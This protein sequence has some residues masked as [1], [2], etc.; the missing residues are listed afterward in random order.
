MKVTNLKKRILLVDSLLVSLLW[1]FP[2]IL[3]HGTYQINNF[4]IYQ[5]LLALL[6]QLLLHAVLGHYDDH[7][8]DRL[9]SRRRILINA[10][11]S[12]FL[13]YF[14]LKFFSLFF[15]HS[16]SIR[17]RYFFLII[18]PL[19]VL[20]YWFCTI[21]NLKN[22][23]I[24]MTQKICVL[25]DKED[26]GR[27]QKWLRDN[28]IPESEFKI[29]SIIDVN[30]SKWINLHGVENQSFHKNSNLFDVLKEH[31]VVIYFPS[32]TLDTREA[33]NLLRFGTESGS[34]FDFGTFCGLLREMYPIDDID[35]DWYVRQS[36][37]LWLKIS[38]YL[39]FRRYFDFFISVILFICSFP[40]WIIA[41]LGI[42]LTSKGPIF[43]TQERI[44]RFGEKFQ[45]IKFRTMTID[46]EKSG[47]QMASSQDKRVTLFG[48]F[49]RRTRI[50]EL[51]QVLNVLKG[52]MSFIGP[53]PEREHFELILNKDL[54]LLQLRNFIAPGIT[55]L[56]QVNGD[57]AN[58]LD[59]Y[60][61]K[62]GYDL[63]YIL[64]LSPVLDLSILLRTVR[65]VLF[66]KGS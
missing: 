26:V 35:T 17:I 13:T 28:N 46:A 16:F 44:G 57:Y 2:I 55:G 61:K 24:H 37:N 7:M 64:N 43:Y 14:I 19:Q 31:D 12:F 30:H 60:R 39:R 4:S 47:P 21:L 11:I 49:L 59:S 15:L 66:K 42:K 1:F 20:G 3:S 36:A 22:S 10:L 8:S 38:L 58:D 63:F 48:R 29:D 25:G 52:E 34:F 65:T 27:L 62:L 32:Q 33:R 5:I 53:R 56:A 50:D 40:L 23:S 18:Y 54:P 45:I 6:S 41:A 9:I 51:P